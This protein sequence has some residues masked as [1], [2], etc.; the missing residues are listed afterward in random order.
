TNGYN[1]SN[2]STRSALY[3]TEEGGYA[4]FKVPMEAGAAVTKL[5]VNGRYCNGTTVSFSISNAVDGTYTDI[6][7]VEEA[8]SGTDV[9]IDVTDIAAGWSEVYVKAT[10]PNTICADWAA[11]YNIRAVGTVNV[12]VEAVEAPVSYEVFAANDFTYNDS[13]WITSS[14]EAENW[15]ANLV[16]TNNVSMQASAGWFGTNGYSAS[17]H[18]TR[19]ALYSTKEGGYAIFKVPAEDGAVIK[20]LI[21]NGRYCYGT[22]VSFSISD[23]KDGTYTDVYTVEEAASGTD[24]KIDIADMVADWA[25]IYVKATFP[26]TACAD[27]AALFNIRVAG[28]TLVAKPDDAEGS[29][30][31]PNPTDQ[32]DSQVIHWEIGAED[33]YDLTS[34]GLSREKITAEAGHVSEGY[35]VAVLE[36]GKS[37]EFKLPAEL[38]GD[39][40]PAMEIR[41][42]HKHGDSDISYTVALN[43]TAVKERTVS[44]LSEGAIHVWVDFNKKNLQEENIVT[45]TNNGEQAIRFESIWFYENLDALMVEE[46]VYTPMEFVLF[47]LPV[48]YQ[49]YET[50]LATVLSYKE[51]YSDYDKYTIG[52][53][54]DIY[55]MIW[56]EEL[57]YERL[58]H[59]MRLSAE[60]DM[61]LYLNLNSW[62]SG[63]SGGMDG[64]G[65]FW[66]DLA[67]Q[68]I[69]YDPDNVN[70][71]GI[72][73]LTTPNMWSSTPWLSMNEEW[74][75]QVRNEKLKKISD[76]I[77]MKQAE[78]AA[79]KNDVDV[80]IFLENEPTYWAYSHYN[81]STV[82]GRADLS[83]TVIQ[84]AAKE[85]FT[86]DPTDGL[87]TEEQLWLFYNHTTY[88][89]AE[90][91]AVQEGL[92]NDAIIIVDGEVTY[93]TTQ[94]S[95]K[96][97]SH[98]QGGYEEFDGVTYPHWE[99]HIVDNL[100]LGLEY[101]RPDSLSDVELQYVLARGTYADV[102][103]ERSAVSNFAVISQLYKYG[104]DYAILFNIKS[105]DYSL[106][107]AQDS[108]LSE[109]SEDVVSRTRS[110]W[111]TKRADVERLFK[112]L[113][114]TITIESAKADYAAAKEAYENGRYK[115]AYNLLMKVQSTASLPIDFAV[116][117]TSQLLD[118][119]VTIEAENAVNITLYEA[120]DTLK[121]KLTAENADGV[122][123]TWDGVT[124]YTVKDLGEG[125]YEFTKGGSESGTATLKAAPYHEKDYPD[126]FEA[127]YRGVSDGYIQVASQDAEIGE[128]VNYVSLK[129]AEDCV[130]TRA[131]DGDESSRT[132]VEISELQA[133]DLVELTLNEADEVV[134]VKAAYG[135]VV[136]RVVSI[137]YPVVD[138]TVGLE[139][140]YITIKDTDGNIREF[141]LCAITAFDYP[142]M[143]GGAV[144]TSDLTDYGLVEGDKI[145]ISYSPYVWKDTSTKAIK[146]YKDD[147]NKTVVNVDFEDGEFGDCYSVENLHIRDLDTNY[148]NQVA[149]TLE[150]EELGSIIWEIQ[151]DGDMEIRDI[152]IEYAARAIMGTSLR[153]Y[154][155]VDGGETWTLLNEIVDD[156][157]WQTAKT[158]HVDDITANTALVKVEIDSIGAEDPD[159]RASLDKI[160]ISIPTGDLVE[161]QKVDELILA[162]GEV[163]KDSANAIEAARKAYDALTDAQKAIVEN[164]DL[165]EEAEKAYADLMNPGTGSEGGNGNAGGTGSEGGSGNASGTGN[166][167]GSENAGETGNEGGTGNAGGTGSGSASGSG[168]GSSSGSQ[169]VTGS[170]SNNTNSTSTTGTTDAASTASPATGD[171]AAAYIPVFVMIALL[172][173]ALIGFCFYRKRKVER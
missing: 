34:D 110:L 59:L 138:G 62:W 146:V 11:L 76:Y 89:E 160:S 145:K 99:C 63:T 164:D 24:V 134:E 120:G 5:I 74:Y 91:E 61:P 53:S 64:K 12:V 97:Y 13:D 115:T 54:F 121:L 32:V 95:E 108:P 85:G 158:I 84:A 173:I 46:D 161:A 77:A 96:S 151:Q 171:E 104:A 37:M 159:T 148:T 94:M 6:Y 122:K 135:D 169:T 3:S 7:T 70:G 90:G 100:R 25:E 124:S 168:N 40:N 166:A 78:Y 133:Y 109:I 21:V 137:T 36:P 153:L 56:E 45:I 150:K 49:D 57:L 105:T 58:D 143:T 23:A 28:T 130:I 154:L 68:Q 4:I 81:S 29:D 60:A 19:S 30:I 107:E 42:I 73:Q 8:A 163:T 136:G 116:S 65:G 14:T 117:G 88:I 92:G 44:P 165:L 67:Y 18:S 149:T 55:Y 111:I 43:G 47:T 127:A 20:Q 140:P 155:S 1:A 48:K 16:E 170:V 10:F 31:D 93:P 52:M 126:Q 38:L 9:E 103:I 87:S 106:V 33:K 113:D 83:Y 156:G 119:P 72:W 82:T 114:G 86:L 80:N 71:Q 131:L 22:A 66:K 17:N 141:E 112:E 102:N 69:I 51:N 118:Y 26:S 172:G 15:D 128:Y 123:V 27:W 50:D 132:E 39:T 152:T 79:E 101:S 147:Y 2:H 139:S 167:G 142:T 157:V 125:I 144:K 98:V 75:N 162:I 35:N 129:L 41:E